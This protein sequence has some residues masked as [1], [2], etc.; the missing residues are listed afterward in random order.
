MYVAATNSS[1]PMNLAYSAN[2]ILHILAHRQVD[3]LSL[4]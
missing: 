1:S 2:E 3:Q 4:D